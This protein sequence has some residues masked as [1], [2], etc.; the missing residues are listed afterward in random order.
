MVLNKELKAIQEQQETIVKQIIAIVNA[1]NYKF[2]LGEEPISIE[3]AFSATGLL[4]AI[5][6]RA[7]QLCSF[8]LGHGLGVTFE[9][10]DASLLGVSVFFDN[11]VAISL[12]L[13]CVT[14]VLL[15]IAYSANNNNVVSLDAL[16]EE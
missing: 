11:K 2:T 14:D 5:M 12:R 13:L 16:T 15:E 10:A 8:C 7:D 1:T 4:P 3:K 9:K 6:R